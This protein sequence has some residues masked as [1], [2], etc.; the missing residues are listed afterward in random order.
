MSTPN[1]LVIGISGASGSPYAK[2]L[3]DILTAEGRF[4]DLQLSIVVSSTAQEVW[5]H[6]VGGK[7]KDLGIQVYGGR[8]YTAPFASGSSV[9]D[10]M[11]IVPCSMS[12]VAR[13]AYGMSDNLLT[14]AADVVLKE[15]RRLVVV[16]RETPYSAVHLE[17]MLKLAQLGATVLPASPSFYGKPATIEQVIDTVVGRLLDHLGFDH[18]LVRRWG[19][20]VNL[21]KP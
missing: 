4:P 13:I 10:A 5:A 12:C 21:G 8:D 17:N 16:P 18:K 7:I 19:P 6:E 2:R 11:V 1:S 15:R 3:I 9:C 14:R 20:D